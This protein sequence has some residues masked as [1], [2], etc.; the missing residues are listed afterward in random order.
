MMVGWGP[1]SMY[2]AYN[3]FYPPDLA[4]WELRN[5]TPDRSHDVFFDQAVTMG[6]LGLVAYLFLIGAFIWYAVRALRKAPELNDQLLIIGLLATV[7]A[8]VGEL[9]TGIQIAATYTYFYM[10]V[11]MTVVLGYVLNDY[12][13]R[14]TP[15]A[16]T[17]PA[18]PGAALD[19]APALQPVGAVAGNGHEEAVAAVPARSSV[20][21]ASAA[22]PNGRGAVPAGKKGYT[23][24]APA[25]GPAA[26]RRAAGGNPPS[27]GGRIRPPGAAPGA[28]A[29]TC[30]R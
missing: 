1:E 7:V 12:L 10:A 29:P 11:A 8:H 21:V 5:A 18:T 28:R 2:V 13:R 3:K 22:K 19:G 4:H 20:A 6:L 25:T 24:V 9:V 17:V 26:G 27:A 14:E 23:A 15:V 16:A 30:A